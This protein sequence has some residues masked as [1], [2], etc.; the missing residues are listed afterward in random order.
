MTAA[1]CS[2]K[3]S[4]CLIPFGDYFSLPIFLHS[5]TT[6]DAPISCDC[7]DQSINFDHSNHPCNGFSFLVGLL[8]YAI[9]D[10]DPLL[11]LIQLYSYETLMEYSYEPMFIGSVYQ[12]TV[13]ESYLTSENRSQLYS[14]CQIK[15]YGTCNFLTINVFDLLND[16]QAV[17]TNYLPVTTGAC[18]NIFSISDAAW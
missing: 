3:P 18:H 6:D 15:G 9:S 13:N 5:G 10:V 11:E 14:F 16:N 8:F 17:G 7:D 12:Y 4:V 1:Y 2:T